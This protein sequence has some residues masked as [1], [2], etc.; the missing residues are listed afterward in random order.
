[1]RTRTTS[2][3]TGSKSRS[4]RTSTQTGVDR[5]FDIILLAACGCKPPRNITD[6]EQGR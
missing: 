6:G 4:R 3:P 1:M 5:N 2:R